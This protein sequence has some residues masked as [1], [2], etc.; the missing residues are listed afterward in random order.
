MREVPL[1]NKGKF[2]KVDDDDFDLVN[3]FRWSA[4]SIRAGR[5]YA[6]RRVN[7]EYIYM[8]RFII[9]QYQVI[10]PGHVVNHMDGDGLNNQRSENLEVVSAREMLGTIMR[11]KV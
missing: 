11:P 2:A 5:W 8:H 1:R 10:P 7:G 9:Q 3:Q 4:K 6:V